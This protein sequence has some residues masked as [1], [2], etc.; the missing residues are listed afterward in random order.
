MIWRSLLLCLFSVMAALGDFPR[1]SASCR[2]ALTDFSTGQP[3]QYY[4]DALG[5]TNRIQD[6]LGFS[7]SYTHD[8]ATG[9]LTSR[10]DPAGNVTTYTQFLYGIAPKANAV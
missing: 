9:W 8:P 10:T 1:H 4:Y 3:T 5:R 2:F 6:P 7:V